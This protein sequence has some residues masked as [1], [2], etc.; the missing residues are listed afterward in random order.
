MVDPITEDRFFVITGG[1]GS[2]GCDRISYPGETSVVTL[3][4]GSVEE[5]VRFVVERVTKEIFS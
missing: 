4:L 3:P 5:R 1:P 2:A